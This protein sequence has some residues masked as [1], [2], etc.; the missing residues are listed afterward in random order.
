MSDKEKKEISLIE[1]T[2][3]TIK[4]IGYKNTI[5]GLRMLRYDTSAIRNIEPIIINEICNY[6][7]LKSSSELFTSNPRIFDTDPI[8]I[9][10]AMMMKY[11]NLSLGQL[12]T[13]IPKDRSQISRYVKRVNMA[14]PNN[15]SD[16]DIYKAFEFIDGRIK[17]YLNK[18]K[19]SED[20]QN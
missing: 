15:V 2:L 6:Y 18:P 8:S 10:C 17:A 14:S 20:Q 11:T 1:E 5:S 19:E 16:E 9:Y 4:Q 7:G 13:R 3:I 12:R